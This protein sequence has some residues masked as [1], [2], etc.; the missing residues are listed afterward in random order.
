MTKGLVV[1]YLI[2]RGP[3][4]SS[5]LLRHPQVPLI[6]ETKPMISIQQMM[7]YQNQKNGCYQPPPP[8]SKQ[9]HLSPEVARLIQLEEGIR[10]AEKKKHGHA[11]HHKREHRDKDHCSVDMNG[12]ETNV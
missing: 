7:T 3:P 12:L 6:C 1:I 9:D 11:S 4:L 2:Y 8:G 5:H 10:P